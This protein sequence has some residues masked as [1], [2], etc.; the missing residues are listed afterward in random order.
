MSSTLA[1]WQTGSFS[2]PTAPRC[3]P[4]AL[5]G[6]AETGPV[7]SLAVTS[8]AIFAAGASQLIAFPTAGCGTERCDASWW[9]SLHPPFNA[10]LRGN[11]AVAGGV[12][13]AASEY[14]R[15]EA[16]DAAGCGG[17]Q[18]C[19]AMTHVVVPGR[20]DSLMVSGG[21]LFVGTE[22]TST[23]DSGMVVTFAPTAE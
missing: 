17:Q 3:T 9:A 1:L 10:Y 2:R 13:Y 12:V 5:A 23:R 16:F 6:A 21:R 8:D 18:V 7:D 20:P 19:S 15:V 14:G 4:S 22:P 11:L